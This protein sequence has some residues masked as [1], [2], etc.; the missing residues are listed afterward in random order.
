M[1]RRK[2]S[3]SFVCVQCRLQLSAAVP[4]RAFSATTPGQR[5]EHI[6]SRQAVIDGITGL[7][8]KPTR[9]TAKPEAIPPPDTPS[10]SQGQPSPPHA[11]AAQETAISRTQE[12]ENANNNDN[13]EQKSPKLFKLVLSG[14]SLSRRHEQKIFEKRGIHPLL[15]T[16]PE[17]LDRFYRR[18]AS[19]EAGKPLSTTQYYKSRGKKLSAQNEAL[20]VDVMGERSS[21]IIL[22]SS[23]AKKKKKKKVSDK[24]ASQQQ[25]VVRSE[26][27]AP[28]AENPEAKSTDM[29]ILETG[30]TESTSAHINVVLESE[31]RYPS[32]SNSLRN[33]HELRP[34][35]SQPLLTNDFEELKMKLEAGFT[36]SQLQ[37]YVHTFHLIPPEPKVDAPQPK[38]SQDT[39]TIQSPWMVKKHPWVPVVPVGPQETDVAELYH[40]DMSPKEKLVLRVMRDCWGISSHRTLEVQGRLDVEM[41]DTEFN[42]LLGMLNIP[43][44]ISTLIRANFLASWDQ[45]IPAR[46]REG[47]FGVRQPN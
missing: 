4:R 2:V 16:E 23:E 41:A 43:T 26:L 15:E 20:S 22:R 27:E 33:I 8:R 17:G 39:P 10:D 11:T 7:N 14:R 37:Q 18:L 44:L 30:E 36:A 13:T 24:V 21:A 35:S 47:L 3:S 9:Q 40:P 45:K 12:P 6:A 46:H 5:N 29:E 31:D 38:E 28:K 1:L 42:L 25:D 19:D 34:K 32:T